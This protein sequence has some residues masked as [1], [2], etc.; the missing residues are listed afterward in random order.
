[1]ADSALWVL[2]LLLMYFLSAADAHWASTIW[3]H[4]DCAAGRAAG[5]L[6][7]VP[8]F[9]D[10]LL[11][12]RRCASKGSMNAEDGSPRRLYSL[13]LERRPGVAAADNHLLS[14]Q[15]HA[16]CGRRHR[17]SGALFELRAGGDVA[18]PQSFLM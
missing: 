4:I 5:V 7:S 9:D 17:F 6:A 12:V 10:V 3:L 2:S 16:G 8:V 18:D 15:R 13:A 1:M 11:L 14:S